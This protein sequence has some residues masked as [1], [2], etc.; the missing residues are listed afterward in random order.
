MVERVQFTTEGH[1]TIMGENDKK[2][3]KCKLADPEPEMP[4]T[5][6]SGQMQSAPGDY[7]LVDKNSLTNLQRGQ[8]QF[9]FSATEQFILTHEWYEFDDD[10]TIEE[11]RAM[12]E[13]TFL[14]Y[15]QRIDPTTPDC[16]T[17]ATGRNKRLS[18]K[19][20]DE[21]GAGNEGD[22]ADAVAQKKAGKKTPAAKI[23]RKTP[24]TKRH[25]GKR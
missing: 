7:V 18:N 9:S 3:A 12:D 21:E 24:A 15:Y 4:S 11:L 2:I 8:K 17:A 20:D 23:P 25:K 22:G 14:L 16:K 13:D 19:S 10:M 1:Y 5:F 6:D